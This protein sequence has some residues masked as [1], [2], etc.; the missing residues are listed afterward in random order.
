MLTKDELNQIRGIVKEENK[1][2]LK[3]VKEDIKQIRQ[4]QNR[5]IAFFDKSYINLRSRVEKIEEVLGI[6]SSN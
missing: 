3:P 2:S 4:D 6:Q 5:I 1:A